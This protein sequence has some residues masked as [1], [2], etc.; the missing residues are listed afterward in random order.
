MDRDVVWFVLVLIT[1]LITE[2]NTQQNKSAVAC[3]RMRC[4]PHETVRQFPFISH[5]HQSMFYA[6]F[7]TNLSF[8]RMFVDSLREPHKNIKR[9]PGQGSC[10]P[11]KYD[12]KVYHTYC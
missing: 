7:R 4:G 1:A 3:T 11:V 9:S 8:L 2:D 12:M 10:D 6:Y 5:H